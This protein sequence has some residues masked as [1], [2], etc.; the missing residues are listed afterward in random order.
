MGDVVAW[1]HVYTQVPALNDSW[2]HLTYIG[3]SSPGHR[4]ISRGIFYGRFYIYN[5]AALT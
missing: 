5:G 2:N 3:G 4:V 1:I